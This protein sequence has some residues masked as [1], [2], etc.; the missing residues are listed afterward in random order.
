MDN[1]TLSTS[2]W[3]MRP[4]LLCH[5]VIGLLLASFFL[6]LWQPLD[7]AVFTFLNENLKKYPSCW[8]W[9]ALANH[10]LADWFED[11]CI[12]G[13]YILSILGTAKIE[14]K[15][16]IWQFVFSALFIAFTILLINR[17]LCRDLLHLR[18]DSPTL[19]ME[20]SLRLSEKVP[21]LT[22]KDESSKSFPGDHATTALLFA[23]TYAFF[24]KRPLSTYG[25]FY[26]SLLCLP[27]L[28]AGAH[29]LSDLVVGSGSIVLFAM[30]WLLFTPLGKKGP[31]WL[32]K[33]L[34]FGRKSFLKL[35]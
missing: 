34:L 10:S 7:Q 2:A 11:L 30:S 31:F 33:I 6:S 28:I 14:R 29:W 23:S 25:Y 5:L 8:G 35:N 17:L 19:S 16:R 1:L 20:G 26:A 32:R 4:L 9:L 12:L 18:R 24:A 15:E 13:F 3:R 21:W 22:V 27:R